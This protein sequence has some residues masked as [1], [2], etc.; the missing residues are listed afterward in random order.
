MLEA[1]QGPV[2]DIVHVV[3]ENKDAGIAANLL[4][5]LD[6]V[7]DTRPEVYMVIEDDDYYPPDYIA[8]RMCDLAGE[9]AAGDAITRYY[10]VPSM[11]HATL[12]NHRYASLCS[13]A[14]TDEALP[15]VHR[16][17]QDCHSR[18]EQFIDRILW[19]EL[20][21]A[22]VSTCLV[23]RARMVGIKGLPGRPGAGMGHKARWY[24]D[25]DLD[26][27]VLDAW[28][29]REYATIYRAMV[30][31]EVPGYDAAVNPREG[32]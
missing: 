13:T 14:F 17:L 27:A 21:S 28:V 23:D 18:G 22:K 2:D 24:S 3:T 11:S 5:C 25:R 6:R 20:R 8:R 31:A 30:A 32:R 12:H 15:V 9:V 10:H 26:G 7:R 29:G 1:Q 4:A 16:V 19:A